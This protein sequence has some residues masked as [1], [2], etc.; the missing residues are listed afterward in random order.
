MSK[1]ITV[2]GATGNQGGSVIKSILGDSTLSKEY[3]IRAVTR[4][5]SKPGAQAL[6]K[7][8]AELVSVCISRTTKSQVLTQ[9]GRPQL[10]RISPQDP[11]WLSFSLPSNQLL[12][13]PQCRHRSD[14]GKERDRRSQRSRGSTNHFLLADQRD[15]SHQRQ[16]EESR[17]L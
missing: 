11:P 8:G 3:K 10:K 5:T 12:G 6:A 7:Q 4:D 1:I 16:I 13:E 14:A 2:F 17:A 9:A 15:E